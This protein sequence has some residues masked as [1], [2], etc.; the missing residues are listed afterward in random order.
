MQHINEQKKRER[1]SNSEKKEKLEL[2]IVSLAIW[3]KMAH[4]YGSIELKARICQ[5]SSLLFT[6]K[7]QYDRPLYF[8][9]FQD[10]MVTWLIP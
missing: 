6:S 7:R 8:I 1:E 10:Y 2:Q 3:T 5:I 9:Y 4:A